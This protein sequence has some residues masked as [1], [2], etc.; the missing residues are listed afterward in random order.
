MKSEAPQVFDKPE[1]QIAADELLL[2]STVRNEASR[3]P[4]FLSFYRHLGV[5]RF[6]IVDNG[7]TD[8]TA[9]VLRSEPDVHYFHTV[10]S[11]AA[12]G[13]GRTWTTE[14]ANQYGMGHWCLTVDADELFV[15]PGIE[16]LS[17]RDLIAYLEDGK[18]EAVFG[19]FLDMYY[20]GALSKAEYVSG[21]P[22]L[23]TCPSFDGDSYWLDVARNFPHVD[24]M[25]GPRWRMFWGPDSRGTGPTMR[26]HVLVKWR[27]GFEYLHSTHSMSPVRVADV[28][29]AVLHFKF[30][31]NFH[32]LAKGEVKRGDRRRMDHYTV[33]KEALDSD[34]E[35]DFSYAG[36]QTYGNSSTLV[37]AGFVSVPEAFLNYF[38]RT[39]GGDASRL[40][41]DAAIEHGVALELPPSTGEF[42]DALVAAARDART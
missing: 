19:V 40:R 24:I 30:F 28:T 15:F 26:K 7:S 22:F 12:S 18:Y 17:C 21:A 39:A 31:S 8:G 23:K 27:P 34:T 11:Y 25:G 4:F 9:D 13:A 5:D 33:Y 14:L 32:D 42:F 41:Y 35:I 2:F 37:R 29:S 38:H 16:A 1:I 3:L 20:P 10:E 6:F 36:T